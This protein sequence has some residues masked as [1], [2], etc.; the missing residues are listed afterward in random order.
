MNSYWGTLARAAAGSLLGA[1]AC[2]GPLTSR[3]VDRPL[4]KAV[5]YGAPQ[6]MQYLVDAAPEHDLLRLYVYER[7]ECAK[8]PVQLV[9]RRQELLDGDDVVETKNVGQ[10][11]IA[12]PPAGSV[13]CD[14]RNARDVEVS[15]LVGG[16]TYILGTTDRDGYVGVN[17]ADRLERGARS[18]PLPP[19]AE[20]RLRPPRG[21]SPQSAGQLSLAEL[22]RHGAEI[23]TLLVEL[24][25]ILSKG[26]AIGP[27]EIARSYTLYEKLRQL[28]FHDARFRAS[29]ARFWEL[30]YGRKQAEAT[31]RLGKNL[32]ALESARALLASAGPAAIPIYAQAAANSGTLDAR[33][34]EWS[35]WQLAS[36]LRTQRA[37]CQAFAW[38]RVPSYG[39][40]PDLTFAL[41]YLHF[42]YGDGYSANISGLCARLAGW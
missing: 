38:E 22:G 28:A 33:A 37:A 2:G 35:E 15:L 13:P 36:G 5:E 29:A 11:Q 19:S 31:E 25:A 4:R 18:E 8:I 23:E 10:V 24:D 17:L 42:A 20:I 16:S 32:K 14:A 26:E 3:Y 21:G 7:S 40:G 9:D 30:L 6:N 27:Q 1:I 41:H 39:F 34:L 12:D